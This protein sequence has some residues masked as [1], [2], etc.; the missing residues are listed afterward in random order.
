MLCYFSQKKL[1]V[2]Y[3]GLNFKDLVVEENTEVNYLI[4]NI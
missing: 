3:L 2:K 1:T 4:F